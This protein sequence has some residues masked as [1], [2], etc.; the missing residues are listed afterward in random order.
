MQHALGDKTFCSI[1][2][3]SQP[4]T[5][6]RRLTEFNGA[7]S[8]ASSA[9][10]PPAPS[11]FKPFAG[12]QP[13]EL[14]AAQDLLQGAAAGFS[15]ALSLAASWDGDSFPQETE[16]QELTQETGPSS[17]VTSDWYY[18]SLKLS[19]GHLASLQ[20]PPGSLKGSA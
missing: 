12:L 10:P 19:A 17:E 1:C 20:L 13:I 15:P 6:H 4:R 16:V 9:E 2:A 3:V 7:V 14:A 11:A 5:L 18:L 8:S